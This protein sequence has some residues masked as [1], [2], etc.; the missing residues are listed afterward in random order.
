MS[1]VIMEREGK[2]ARTGVTG[3]ATWRS[4]ICA[5]RSRRYGTTSP[6]PVFAAVIKKPPPQLF[7]PFLNAWFGPAGTVSPLH[8]DP[9]YNILCQVVGKRYVRLY[10]PDQSEKL[11]SRGEEGGIDMSN[12]SQL[13][14]EGN[15]DFIEKF[16]LFKEARY[17]KTVLGRGGVFVHSGGMVALCEESGCELQR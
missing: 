3:W 2:R 7:E 13:D 15:E 12:T 9:Y 5:L 8:T 14:A 16:P 6:S 10:N 11:Y 4:M 17:V 1:I